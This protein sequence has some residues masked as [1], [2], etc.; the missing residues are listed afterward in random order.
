MS[1]GGYFGKMTYCNLCH[2]IKFAEVPFHYFWDNRKFKGVKC[3]SCG[4]VTID[5]LPTPEDIR[6]LYS[7]GYFID[8]AHTLDKLRM[9]YEELADQQSRERRIEYI[10]T[11]ILKEKPDT[12]SV[13]EIGAAIGHFLDAAK[14]L[15]LEVSGVEISPEACLKAKR[16]FGIDLI[17][18]DFEEIDISGMESKWDCV[19]AGDVFEHFRN[20]SLV[21]S[22]I[23]Q[24]LS[25]DGIVVIRIPST[26]NLLSTKIAMAAFKM[27]RVNKRLPDNPYHLYEYTT[28][29]IKRMFSKYFFFAQITV[30]NDIKKP[31]ELNIKS[32]TADYL[33]KYVLQY[34]NYVITKLFYEFGDRLTVVARK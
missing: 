13:F 4:L 27:L 26:F 14:E 5:P 10:R 19:F 32:R 6:R 12:K 7:E 20:P 15:N 21:L 23:Y 30:C 28:E 24:I 8:G 16:R 22:K 33:L 11:R 25:E 34:F 17:Q 9:T 3:T 18:G 2:S 31:W 29:T 1:A